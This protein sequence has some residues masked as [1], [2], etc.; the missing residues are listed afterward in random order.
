MKIKNKRV[1]VNIH[2][3]RCSCRLLSSMIMLSIIEM[4]DEYD[5]DNNTNDVFYDSYTSK[6]E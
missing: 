1:H 5:F 4:Q 3:F 2:D 6:D